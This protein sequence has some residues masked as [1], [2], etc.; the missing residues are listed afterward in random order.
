MLSQEL[1]TAARVRELCG[2]ICDMT[3]WRW[4]RDPHLSFPQPVVIRR[5]K[6]YRAGEVA[7]FIER[8]TPRI[9]GEAA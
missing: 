3:L 6:F 7:E 4:G 2:G 1:I 9:V 5:R 8:Q